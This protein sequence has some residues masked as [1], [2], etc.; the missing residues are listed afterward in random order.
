[1]AHCCSLHLSLVSSRSQLYPPQI[2]TLPPH[3]RPTQQT[4]TTSSNSTPHLLP[5]QQV[6]TSHLQGRRRGARGVRCE[7]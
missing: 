4:T 5:T 1:M 6:Q 3:L 7:K 2:T